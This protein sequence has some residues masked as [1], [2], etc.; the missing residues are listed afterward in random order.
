MLMPAGLKKGSKERNKYVKD[1]VWRLPR[2]GK[3]R[4]HPNKHPG[5]RVVKPSEEQLE[6]EIGEARVHIESKVVN[7]ESKISEL[8]KGKDELRA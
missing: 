2:K 4:Q 6:K 3:P 7:A 8:L 1:N 5:L